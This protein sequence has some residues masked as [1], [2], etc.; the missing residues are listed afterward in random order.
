MTMRSASEKYLLKWKNHQNS[1]LE[2]LDQLLTRELLIDVTLACDGESYGAHKVVLCA[3][4][5][6]FQR[7]LSEN[8]CKHPIIVLKDVKSS[9][10]RALIEFMYKGEICV[11]Q[12][13]IGSLL[14]T[15]EGLQI[16][17]LCETGAAAG[18]SMGGPRG[19]EG[20][21]SDTKFNPIAPHHPARMS[22]STASPSSS[23]SRPQ[24]H[25]LKQHSPLGPA[26]P[27][28]APPFSSGYSPLDELQTIR[29]APLKRTLL[30]PEMGGPGAPP[31]PPPSKRYA[32]TPPRL[33]IPSF[34][35]SAYSSPSPSSS[36]S[37]SNGF[38]PPTAPSHHHP[39]VPPGIPLPSSQSE[40]H[41]LSPMPPPESSGGSL[42]TT[43]SLPPRRR[44]PSP[45]RLRGQP[46]RIS[47]LTTTAEGRGG[48]ENLSV[49]AGSRI[50]GPPEGSSTT[51]RESSSSTTGE[52]AG[53]PR[54]TD[55]SQTQLL[56][57]PRSPRDVDPSPMSLPHP[58]SWI[59]SSSPSSSVKG[60]RE[61]PYL[62]VPSSST[63]LLDFPSR[64]P[65][66][67]GIPS[68][69]TG[70][71]GAS[72]SG[73]QATYMEQLRVHFTQNF[74]MMYRLLRD[75]S[76]DVDGFHHCIFC[77]KQ[78][79]DASNFKKHL[80]THTGEKP[81]PCTVC[82]R[83][84]SRS[85]NLKMHMRNRHPL[86]AQSIA[87]H[88]STVP[89][90]GGGGG[91]SHP[92][93]TSPPSGLRPLQDSPRSG[94]SPGSTSSGSGVIRKA[95]GP[96]GAGAGAQQA[97]GSPTEREERPATDPL[98]LPR[99]EPPSPHSPPISF[100]QGLLPFQQQF[101]SGNWPPFLGGAASG[102]GR[103]R[104]PPPPEE[105]TPDQPTEG[106]DLPLSLTMVKTE[107]PLPPVV[108]SS[109]GTKP[110]SVSSSEGGE[111]A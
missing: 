102:S 82:G 29:Q 5:P 2:V 31:A 13:D 53:S 103:S 77:G 73:F 15:A 11:S 33:P 40:R 46:G 107:T 83:A 65:G 91:A 39:P 80:R 35:A 52:A 61:P 95:E 90:G 7:V 54:E 101:S 84:F 63:G 56:P 99:S 19:P 74:D 87:Q 57:P 22:F 49:M 111:V 76:K 12:A 14:K 69:S 9:E 62:A 17:G 86:A 108:P 44:S 36:S 88:S 89:A 104:S 25:P 32:M 78:I 94:H 42:V 106:G 30:P 70:H 93:G 64:S 18:A 1:F 27:P 66:G 59:S 47:P 10:L 68:S 43:S 21:S 79:R 8:P 100:P 110:G 75:R 16:R 6:F 105:T 98:P 34:E 71:Q 23:A 97:H 41:R 3:C 81:Y 28:Q 20:T 37:I 67:P 26:F 55:I 96:S 50:G 51:D 92:G 72:S 85:E 109:T 45:D 4:S 58:S 60:E 38:V 48:P 24:P